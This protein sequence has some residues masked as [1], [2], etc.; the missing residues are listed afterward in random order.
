MRKAMPVIWLV[1]GLVVGVGVSQC[2]LGAIRPVEASDS[3]YEDFI[4][5]TGR[6]MVAPHNNQPTDG[7]WIL[8]YRAGKLLGTV[9]DRGAG[10]ISGWAEVDLVT[11]FG[12][13]PKQ[14][15]HFMM[16]TGS[17]TNGQAAL[18]L[19]E[20]T[21]GKVGVYTMGPNLNGNGLAIRRH[22]M[23]FFRSP[24]QGGK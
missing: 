12:I 17:I 24:P 6:V 13:Q 14:N 9:V 18:Y 22:D 21:T 1:V 11:E 4:M 8:D 16:T 19:T 2:Y 15:V 5:C 3:R 7:L 20:T 10:K 23:V